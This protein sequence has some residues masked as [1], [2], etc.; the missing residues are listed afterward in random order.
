MI[1]RADALLLKLLVLLVMLSMS[2]GGFAGSLDSPNGK[3]IL[4]VSGNIGNTNSGNQARFDRDMLEALGVSEL[5][6]ETRWTAGRQVFNGVLASKVLDAVAAQGEV[7]VARAI[8]D[9]EVKI[10]L[11]DLRR[12]PVLF[13]L[14]QNGSY[15]RVRDKG[16]IW[17]IYPRETFPEIDT[18]EISDR[19]VWQL[20]EIIIQ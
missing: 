10:P 11:S 8:N 19:W 12:Y 15:M 18:E 14:K 3:V 5:A 16:P 1:Y 4:T 17:V 6:L 13:A 20:S 7:V 2:P 9:Y